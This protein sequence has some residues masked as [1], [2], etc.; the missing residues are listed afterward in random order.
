MKKFVC[1]HPWAHFEVNNPN[2]NVT[3]CCNNDTVLGNVNERNIDDIWNGEAFVA[4]RE[5]MKKEGAQAFCPH[6]CPVL[7]GGKKYENLDW[8]RELDEDG[9]PRRNAELNENEFRQR[10]TRLKSKPRWFRFTYSYA[11]NL[12][13]YHCYQREDA[14]VRAKLPQNFINQIPDYARSAQVVYPFGGEPF[15]FGPVVKLL[16]N[17]NANLE[18]RFYF[19]TNATLLTD[20]NYAILK[21]VPITCMAVSLDAATAESFEALRVRGKNADW[22]AVMANLVKLKELKARKPFTF[23]L[24][25]TLNSVNALEIEKFVEL[26]LS[27]DA[28]PLISLV[29]NPFSTYEFQKKYL[30]FTDH[31][32]RLMQ[33]QIDNSLPLVEAKKLDDASIYLRQLRSIL[34]QHKRNSNGRLQFQVKQAAKTIFHTLPEQL[35]IPVRT[36]VQKIRINQLNRAWDQA[37]HD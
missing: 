3:M 17:H 36:T 31:Q 30:T 18:T 8:F 33:E 37:G 11:C 29:A 6:T 10:L 15:Y 24:S 7:R 14:K 2:G 19:I 27:N 13:C 26:A 5:R 28:E 21:R 35:Q 12:D 34:Q 4:I 1:K 23:T 20:R 9:E 32:F 25:M 16:E 22:N